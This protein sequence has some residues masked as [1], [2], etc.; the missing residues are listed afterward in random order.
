MSKDSGSDAAERAEQRDREREERIRQGM[1]QIEQ[2]FG[3]GGAT[4]RRY[5]VGPDGTETPYEEFIQTQGP[6]NADMQE[7][8]RTGGNI[9]GP[10]YEV[11]SREEQTGGQFGPEF[12][13]GVRQANMDYLL[14]D[15][16]RQFEDA[17]EQLTYALARGGRLRSTT[18]GERSADL[19]REREDVLSQ[20]DSRAQEAVNQSRAAIEDER[21]ALVAMLQSTADPE[22]TANAAR[23]RSEYLS[24]PQP[25][26]RIG[27]VFQNATAGLASAL[28]PRYDAYGQP[29]RG[30]RSYTTR[31]R[32]RVIGG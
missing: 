18:A 22:A 3:S 5:V 28:Q 1:D 24:D 16:N 15:V 19:S 10:G 31:D 26:Q 14:P 6:F 21:A 27:P 17:R 11:V 8:L 2:I 12:F 20:V 4:T 23:A 29:V 32:S 13:E 9:F 25:L 30:S 7:L